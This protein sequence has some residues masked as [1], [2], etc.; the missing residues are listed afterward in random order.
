[1]TKLHT[2]SS[3]SGFSARFSPKSPP[4]D[5]TIEADLTPLLEYIDVNLQVLMESMD[6]PLALRVV[7]AVWD[8]VVMGVEALVVGGGED[9]GAPKKAVD[10]GRVGFLKRGIEFLAAWFWSDGEGISEEELNTPRFMQ[11]R[12]MM[13]GYHLGK[14]ELQKRWME[15]V[16]KQGSHGF[17]NHDDLRDGDW[18]LKLIRRKGGKEFVDEVIGRRIRYG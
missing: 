12:A 18:M 3:G 9:A 2:S 5:P 7:K 1:M 16:G 13:E 4:P 6:Q 15:E 8:Q 17:Q 14:K 11:L 10:A